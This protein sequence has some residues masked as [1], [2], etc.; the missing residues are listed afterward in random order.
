MTRLSELS[1]AAARHATWSRFNQTFAFLGGGAIA[2]A[3]F[4]EGVAEP[5]RSGLVQPLNLAGSFLV[6]VAASCAFWHGGLW[7]LIAAPKTTPLKAVFTR[8]LDYF[9]YA[10]AVLS[11]ALIVNELQLSQLRQWKEFSDSNIE[12][13]FQRMES[14]T[15]E[16]LAAACSDLKDL[17]SEDVVRFYIQIHVI[18]DLCATIL[19]LHSGSKTFSKKCESASFVSHSN[20]MRFAPLYKPDPKAAALNKLEGICNAHSDYF[21]E[22]IKRDEIDAAIIEVGKIPEQKSQRWLYILAFVIGL[23]LTRTTAETIDALRDWRNSK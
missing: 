3:L 9:W 15:P 22:R 21:K 1:L 12:F 8:V 2:W 20:D 17:N 16:H 11:A 7:W 4:S 6:F 14:S 13:N 18:T 23:R 10:A 19:P 5:G